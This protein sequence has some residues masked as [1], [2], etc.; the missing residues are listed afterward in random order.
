MART[1]PGS[2]TRNRSK[3]RPATAPLPTRGKA[4]T[5]KA[6]VTLGA[7]A[8]TSSSSPT[9]TISFSYDKVV[10]KYWP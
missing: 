6:G 8:P 1:K 7:T 3:D 5:V 9:E 2:S 10:W 4:A